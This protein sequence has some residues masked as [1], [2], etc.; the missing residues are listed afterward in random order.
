[1]NYTESI[2]FLDL[3]DHKLESHAT[4]LADRIKAV[5]AAP[6]SGMIFYV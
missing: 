2:Y 5:K 4:N 6:Y 1:M 3:S